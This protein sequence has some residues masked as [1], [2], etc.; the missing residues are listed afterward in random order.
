MSPSDNWW[1][2]AP[3]V[4]DNWW[5]SAPI[6]E[7][8]LPQ[9]LQR[10]TFE[11]MMAAPQPQEPVMRQMP[12]LQDIPIG[13]EFQEADPIETEIKRLGLQIGE[14]PVGQQM[15]S[16][17][18][19]S[20]FDAYKNIL[21]PTTE[22]RKIQEGPLKDTIIYRRPGEEKFTTVT[23]PRRGA[24]LGRAAKGAVEFA[25]GIGGIAGSLGGA[26]L[27]SALG[28]GAAT[29]GTIVGAGL[30]GGLAEATRLAAGVETGAIRLDEKTTPRELAVRAG[31]VGGLE[32]LGA[33]GGLMAMRAIKAIFM[34]A[35]LPDPGPVEEIVQEVNRRREILR[36]TG[37]IDPAEAELLS[38]QMTTGRL[39]GETPVGRELLATEQY[40][41]R[42]QGPAGRSLAERTKQIEDTLGRLQEAPRALGARGAAVPESG[43]FVPPSELGR[44]VETVAPDAMRSTMARMEATAVP[45]AATSRVTGAP[46]QPTQAFIDPSD[47]QTSEQ[48]RGALETLERNMT[49]VAGNAIESA[50]QRGLDLESLAPTTISRLNKEVERIQ[51]NLAQPLNEPTKRAVDSILNR[52]TPKAPELSPESAVLRE[53]MGMGP[54]QAEPVRVNYNN[55][56]ATLRVIREEEDAFLRSA[57]GERT[58][59]QSVLRGIKKALIADRNEALRQLPDGERIVTDLTAAEKAYA[60]VKQQFWEGGIRRFIS[61]NS[62]GGD[63]IADE[64]FAKQLLRN[65]EAAAQIARVFETY[66][67]TNEREL[68][69]STLRWDMARAAGAW[70][71]KRSQDVNVEALNT[72]IRNN[73]GVLRNFFSEKELR[74]MNRIAG[75]S[76]G[77]RRVLGVKDGQDPSKWFTSFYN[78]GNPTQASEVMKRLRRFDANNPGSNLTETVQ[79]YVKN[80]IMTEASTAKPDGTRVVDAEKVLDILEK[81]DRS[82]YEWFA[83]VVDKDFPERLRQLANS[84]QIARPAAAGKAA[85]PE[86]VA[87]GVSE[88]R[89]K[90]PF[91]FAPL[92]RTGAIVRR[93]IQ[94]FSESQRQKVAMAMLD[95]EYYFYLIERG[96]ITQ[97]QRSAIGATG[98]GAAGALASAIYE[99]GTSYMGQQETER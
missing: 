74:D 84:M 66:G 40:L 45:P 58:V 76:Q 55:I 16:G 30:L 91:V 35:G 89:A 88:I 82:R 3:V 39:A 27:G 18:G 38:Q 28:P 86:Q 59:N 48:L 60:Q 69:R 2:S 7:Q 78:D 87:P 25:P 97:A 1:E 54:P 17:T 10:R 79:A 6:A 68:I 90:L 52:L 36:R 65:P 98:A 5:E 31:L 99:R 33:A 73:G 51:A 49:R 95:P 21:G 94:N 24:S 47:V 92:S 62:T 26:A 19:L 34:R 75:W 41:E 80:R 83:K 13:P 85:G 22:V 46:A 44:Q 11:Q 77:V 32:A 81:G 70:T 43:Q 50:K 42:Q 8:Q 96:R 64:V 14:L 57:G 63:T 29:A 4:Q 53:S 72:Y 12:S 37:S 20:E 93:A 71:A 15:R 56:E 9:E 61:T 67:A 23:D